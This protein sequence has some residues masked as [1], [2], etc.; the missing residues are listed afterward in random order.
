METGTCYI[1]TKL[2]HTS[3]RTVIN[4]FLSGM[5]LQKDII[6]VNKKERRFGVT[7]AID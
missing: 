7:Q 4:P 5:D 1:F 2:A 3:V 6:I